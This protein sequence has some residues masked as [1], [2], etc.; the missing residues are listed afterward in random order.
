LNTCLAMCFSTKPKPV[1]FRFQQLT[2]LNRLSK[3]SIGKYRAILL[4]SVAKRIS[5]S[6]LLNP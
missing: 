2:F 5:F 6:I 1:P 3:S 4:K